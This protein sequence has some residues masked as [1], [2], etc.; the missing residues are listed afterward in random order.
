MNYPETKTLSRTDAF[1][2]FFRK[3]GESLAQLKEDYMDFTTHYSRTD[4]AFG[5]KWI[6]FFNCFVPREEIER[7]FDSPREW[8]VHPSVAG[9]FQNARFGAL[10]VIDYADRC[11]LT[12][13]EG[14]A[15]KTMTFIQACREFFKHGEWSEEEFEFFFEDSDDKWDLETR[16]YLATL[17]RESP[18]IIVQRRL[19]VRDF[20]VKW[21]VG[22]YPKRGRHLKNGL[23]LIPPTGGK[24]FFDEPHQRMRKVRAD[25]KTFVSVPGIPNHYFCQ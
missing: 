11:I 13:G 21:G 9:H 7:Y 20:R 16:S 1:G 22:E 17:V 6:T 24:I 10:P 4:F 25:K 3:I 12:E 15:V 19:P 8:L 14:T 2:I 23:I 18:D 5:E